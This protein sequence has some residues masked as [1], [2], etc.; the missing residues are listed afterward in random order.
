MIAADTS[1]LV[2]FF[3]GESGVD[4]RTVLQ[5]LESRSLVLPPVVVT[6]L[7]SDAKMPKDLRQDLLLVPI[8][9]LKDGFWERAG[10]M[11]ATLISKHLKARL[12]DTL[13]AQ[14]CV[15]HDVALITRCNLR[16]V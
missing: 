14:V 9:S 13:I 3:A 8:F 15:D 11:R 2:A 12:A 16:L 4:V 7:L 10:A 6:E 1:S 5:S